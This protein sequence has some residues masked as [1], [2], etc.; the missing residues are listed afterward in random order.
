LEEDEI[1]KV[2]RVVKKRNE[3]L[4]LVD[5]LSDRKG[6]SEEAKEPRKMH[7]Y[8][9]FNGKQQRFQDLC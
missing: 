2:V 5:R 3:E 9:V 4:W 1:I 7:A 6:V 8:L